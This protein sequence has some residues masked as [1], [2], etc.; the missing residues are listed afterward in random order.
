M[1]PRA[2]ALCN[3]RAGSGL[4]SEL[5]GEHNTQSAACY[6]RNG[7]EIGSVYYL[8][9]PLLVKDICRA[10]ARIVCLLHKSYTYIYMYRRTRLLVKTSRN[11]R[12]LLQFRVY[13]NSL[14]AGTNTYNV[15]IQCSV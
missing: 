14:Y 3:I 12:S 2:R 13:T 4:Y 6:T 8:P 7:H 15:C 10:T 1:C 11:R 9:P 5:H